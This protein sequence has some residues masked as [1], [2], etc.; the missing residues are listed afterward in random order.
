MAVTNGWG[1]SLM[2]LSVGGD[3]DAV[4]NAVLHASEIPVGTVP[5]H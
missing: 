2:D 1:D 4:K 5:V 3:L